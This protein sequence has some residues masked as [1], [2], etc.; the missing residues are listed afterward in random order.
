MSLRPSNNSRSASS[1]PGRY[2][3]L[4]AA[5]VLATGARAM[6]DPF[7]DEPD[8]RLPREERRLVAGL[9]ERGMPELVEELLAGRPTMYRVYVARAHAKAGLG[10]KSPDDRERFLAKAAEEYRRVIRL[11]RDRD[12]LRGERRRFDVVQWHIELADMI[13][14]YWIAPDLDRF[15]ITSG[16]DFDRER[17]MTRLNEAHA[18][19]AS[20]ADALDRFDR[21]LRADEDKYL[22]LGLAD[23][24]ERLL[25][26]RQLN[27][28][29]TRLYLVIVGGPGAPQSADLLAGAQE[30]F[31]DVIIQSNDPRQRH[32]AKLGRA[33]A[34][35]EA[36]KPEEALDELRDV[37][38]SAEHRDITARAGYERARLLMRLGRFRLA[39]RDL[40]RLADQPTGRLAGEETGA[41]FYIRLAPLIHAYTFVLEANAEATDDKDRQR[42]YTQ[43]REALLKLAGRGGSWP[44]MTRIY[45]DAIAG[46]R[47]DWDQLS[48]VELTLIAGRLMADEEYEEALRAWTLL[49]GGAGEGSRRHEARFNQGVCL[50]QL[51]RVRPAAEVFLVEARDAPPPV[52][53]KKVFEYSFRCWRELAAETRAKEDYARLAEAARLFAGNQPEHAEASEAS[54]VSALALEESGAHEEAIQEYE[55]VPRASA[56]YW[57]AR[58]NAARCH[59]RLFEALPE[60]T[61]ATRRQGR[62]RRA[63]E[64]WVKL[65]NDLAA[66]EQGA[67]ESA[68]EKKKRPPKDERFPVTDAQLRRQWIIDAKSAAAAL[69]L[70][71][72]LRDY[73]ACLA[74]LEGM[75]RSARV[76]GLQIRCL[77][78]R[79]DIDGA[80]RLLEVYLKEGSGREVGGILMSLAA[81]MESEIDRLH[82][83]GRLR[84]AKQMAVDTLPTIRHLLDWVRQRPGCAEH[85]SV[86]RFSLARTLAR[87]GR[88]DESMDVFEKL[89]ASEPSN[90]AYIREA[91]LLQERIASMDIVAD[92][93]A[94][95]ARAEALWA[96]LLADASLRE[97]APAVYWEARYHWLARQLVHGRAA[98]VVEGIASEQAW[99]PDLGGP[100]WQG[101]LLNL[102]EEARSM[103][104]A[105]P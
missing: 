94:A 14:R 85:V 28:A 52:I 56:R 66:L 3:I 17:L 23:S 4:L 44:D 7:D 87:A 35:R 65:A 104:E 101:R 50:F 61:G 43:A 51:Q 9:I 21:A 100:P 39:R 86:V 83:V 20:V 68:S 63:V 12:W 93:E 38:S 42:L 47:R 71:D 41:L 81:E 67:V 97:T 11:G 96:T 18:L 75:P 62:A 15:E 103:R 105:V 45:L 95:K 30:A 36:G 46:A 32:N 72:D 73:A 54:W 57:Y 78:G 6:A 48:P 33:M 60:D 25:A 90:G 29:W 59:Q 31:E 27:G 89:M 70:S 19:Y 98:M 64:A 37:E 16:L 79:G 84:D 26:Q 55:A 92:R 24:I 49:L 99:Y 69:L 74:L 10:A 13:L 91:A 80:T 5:L 22:L 82:R 88:L 58:R 53:A 2:L 40:E 8:D 102:A 77:Q 1:S 34:R 76:L